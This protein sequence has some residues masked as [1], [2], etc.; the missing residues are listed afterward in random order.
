MTRSAMS[1]VAQRRQLPTMAV[2]SQRIEGEKF[3]QT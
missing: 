3:I 2:V 1:V